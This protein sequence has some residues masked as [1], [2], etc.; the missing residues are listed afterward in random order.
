MI[1]LRCELWTKGSHRHVTELGTL[2][3]TNNGLGTPKLATYLV[4]LTGR[5]GANMGEGEVVGWR[6]MQFNVWDLI[7]TALMV[8]RPLAAKR[9]AKALYGLKV[10]C[11]PR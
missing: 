8:M 6:R 11:R 5:S 2:V 4:R 7:L 9:A 10:P 3:L 1:V